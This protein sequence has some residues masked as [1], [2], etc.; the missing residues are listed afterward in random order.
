MAFEFV[1]SE[2]RGRVGLVTLDRPKA[3]NALCA[4]LVDELAAL[5]TDPDAKDIL[6]DGFHGSPSYWNVVRG[7][8]FAT[9]D[10]L[11]APIPRNEMVTYE[12]S[13]NDFSTTGT[14]AGAQANL[15][16]NA[17]LADLGVNVI[18]LLPEVLRRLRKA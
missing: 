13:L 1:L 5:V 12:I 2:K 10:P 8:S 17:D 18:E 14:F 15:T 16:A 9:P 11:P 6:P 3:L 4:Q 7:R